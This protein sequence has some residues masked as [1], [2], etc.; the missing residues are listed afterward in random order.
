M[1]V[2]KARLGYHELLLPLD[3]V[4]KIFQQAYIRIQTPINIQNHSF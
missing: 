3:N 1:I 2:L 4:S